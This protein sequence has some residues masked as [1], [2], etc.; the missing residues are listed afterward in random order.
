MAG[1]EYKDMNRRE[2]NKIAKQEKVGSKADLT[3]GAHKASHELV[4]HIIKVS[5]CDTDPHNDRHLVEA[6]QIGENIRPKTVHGNRKTD[7]K[8][9]KG[10]MKKIDENKPL[11]RTEGARAVQAYKGVVSG[12]DAYEEYSGYYSESLDN[13]RFLLGELTVNDGKPGRPIKVKN[14]AKK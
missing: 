11:D 4:K 10:I 6:L 8:N 9:D 5:A 13:V 3:D 12:M 2:I 14:L 1:K 7:T